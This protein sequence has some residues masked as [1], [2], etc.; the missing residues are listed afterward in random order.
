MS[1][2]IRA[3]NI[4]SDDGIFHGK[5]KVFVQDKKHLNELI[6]K[7]QTIE[8]VKSVKRKLKG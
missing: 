3:I 8:G 6:K 4:S 2:N 5:I 7:I 1:V